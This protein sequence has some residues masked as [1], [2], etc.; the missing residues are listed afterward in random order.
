[1]A[2]LY[3]DL[4]PTILSWLRG[5]MGQSDEASEDIYHDAVIKF[6]ERYDHK[7]K[8][9]NLMVQIC[10]HIVYDNGKH[11]CVARNKSSRVEYCD[12]EHEQRD[13]QDQLSG[14]IQCEKDR[15]RRE[16]VLSA[17][18]GRLYTVARMILDGNGIEEITNTLGITVGQYRGCVHKIYSA[19]KDNE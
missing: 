19:F 14:L 11:D 17:L 10:K 13:A 3:V 2:T 15:I 5:M 4:R 9:L 6:R 1:M 8:P 16:I 12:R 18:R 7:R